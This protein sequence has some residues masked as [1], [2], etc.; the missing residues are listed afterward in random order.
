M[1][2]AIVYLPADYDSQKKY[3][4][5]YLMHGGWGNETTTL[6]TPT[7]STEFRVLLTI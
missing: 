4:V 7:A 5:L 3:N 6:G 2:R 1:K